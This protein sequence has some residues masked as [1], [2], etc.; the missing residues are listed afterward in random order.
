MDYGRRSQSFDSYDDAKRW[1][2]QQEA[3]ADAGEIF[4]LSLAHHVTLA[5]LI[6]RFMKERV[7]GWRRTPTAEHRECA[8]LRQLAGLPLSQKKLAKLT[9]EDFTDFRVQRMRGSAASTV[10]K[11]LNALSQVIKTA[12]TEWGYRLPLNP[13]DSKAVRRPDI[14][15]ERDRILSP[16]ET[17]RLWRALSQCENPFVLPAAQFSLETALRRGELLG[18]EWRSVDLEARTIHVCQVLDQRSAEVQKSTKNKTSRYVPLTSRAVEILRNLPRGRTT[19]PVFPVSHSLLDSAFGR[20]LARAKIHDFR[21]HDLRHCAITC[22]AM[23][24]PIP[25]DLMKITGHRTLQQLLRYYTAQQA[26]ELAN[27]LP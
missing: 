18:L 17:E 8:Q 19:K 22:L 9:P 3:A 21:W 20:A 16:T 5:E 25:M 11:D 10:C 1:A 14:D 2:R 4:D 6:E 13:C 7:V 12:M 26:K 24:V 23:H 27:K 15:N